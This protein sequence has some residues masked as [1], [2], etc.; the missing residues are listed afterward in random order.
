MDVTKERITKIIIS[1]IQSANMDIK[2][3]V[4][5]TGVNMMYDFIKDE[6]L[7]DVDRVQAACMELPDPMALETYV[8]ILTIHELGHAMDREA[9]QSSLQRAIELYEAK[10][11]VVADNR[12][13]DLTY[14]AM[15]LE[16]HESDIAFEKTAWANAEILNRFFG[17]AEWDS[18]EK[19]K[20]HSL[21]TY[22]ASFEKDLKL[23]NELLG[24][25]ELLIL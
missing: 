4:E 25:T 22:Q 7:V 11:L 15:L 14:V 24:G 20:V 12:T 16:E 3:K 18:F 6:V 2:L 8:R 1:T 9:L 10:K 5:Q 19:V 21:S 23:Y 17:I 13:T